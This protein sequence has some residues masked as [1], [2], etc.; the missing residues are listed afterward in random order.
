MTA[1][2]RAIDYFAKDRML[3]VTWSADHVGRYPTKY[4]RCECACAGCVDERTGART[5]DPDTIPDDIDITNLEAVGNYAIR[6][7][8]SDGHN[9]GIYSW[10]HLAQ[11]C[12]C[13]RCGSSI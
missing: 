12:P 1:A 4:V 8:W 3:Q 7:I 2:P 5:L 11:L 9:T 13:E 6:I 10:E